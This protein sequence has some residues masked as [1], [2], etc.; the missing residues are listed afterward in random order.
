[1][2][3]TARAAEPFFRVSHV[4]LADVWGYSNIDSGQFFRHVE[5]RIQWYRNALRSAGQEA[6]LRNVMQM[7]YESMADNDPVDIAVLAAL[8]W[9]ADQTPPAPPTK[10]IP[11]LPAA[12][13]VEELEAA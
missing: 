11:A 7:H 9:A 8:T 1:M 2:H 4:T 3:T 13:Q 6:S 5:H 10:G 12:G